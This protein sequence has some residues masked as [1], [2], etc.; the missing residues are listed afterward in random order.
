L[1]KSRAR[2]AS[3][4]LG[5]ALLTVLLSSLSS[6]LVAPLSEVAHLFPS[7]RPGSVVQPAKPPAPGFVVASAS[8]VNGSGSTPI[9]N[10]TVSV[11]V[12]ASVNPALELKTNSSGEAEASVAPGAYVVTVSD[13]LFSNTTS[14]NVYSNATTEAQVT[15]SELADQASFA[16]LSDEDSSGSVAPWQSIV[17]AVSASS[18][19]ANKSSYFLDLSYGPESITGPLTSPSSSPSSLLTS[20][21]R[22]AQVPVTVVSSQTSAIGGAPLLWLTLR[23]QTFVLLQ[24]MQSLDLATYS[25]ATRVIYHGR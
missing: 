25:A 3:L 6:G 17:V 21:G 9:P 22:Q 24:G 15:V 14:L 16:D 8:L 2:T 18:A 1:K 11:R 13:P 5:L 12:Q 7:S 10:A 4:V 20:L 19:I 23:P